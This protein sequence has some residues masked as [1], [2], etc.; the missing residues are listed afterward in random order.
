MTLS[1]NEN[2]LTVFFFFSSILLL[3]FRKG[4]PRKALI[5]IGEI[6]IIARLLEPLFDTQLRMIIS[7]IGIG[8]FMMFFP[9]FISHINADEEESGGINLGIGFVIA[10]ALSIFFRALNSSIDITTYGWYQVIG[11]ILGI[12]ETILLLGFYYLRDETDTNLETGTKVEKDATPE[13]SAN[14]NPIK[15]RASILGITLGLSSIIVLVTFVFNGTTVLARW[16]E[17]NYMFITSLM[18]IILSLFALVAIYKPEKMFEFINKS[19]IIWIWNGLF[20]LSLVLTIAVNQV[21]FPSTSDNFPIVVSATTI[22]HQIPL[23]LLILLLPIIF[24]DFI[25]LLRQLIKSKPPMQKLAGSFTLGGGLYM[26]LIIFSI[27][28]T[29]TWGFVKPISFYFR[30]QFW[31]VF[32]IDGL[33]ILLSIFLLKKSGFELDFKRSYLSFKTKISAISLIA[34]VC[35]GTIT[36][37]I[38]IEAKPITQTGDTSLKILTYNL[39]QGVDPYTQKNYDGQLAL[40]RE[41]DADIIGLQETSKIAGNSDVV[42]YFADKLNM[43]SYFGPRGVT[44]TTGVALLSKYP[45]KNAVT[46]YHFSRDSDR[47]QTAT[48]EAEITI[49]TQTFTIYVTHTYGSTSAKSM[50]INDTLARADGKDNVIFMGD[51]NFR[52]NS[53]PYNLTTDVLVDAWLDQW[54]SGVDDDSVNASSRI[55]HIFLGALNPGLNIVDCR[56][57]EWIRVESDHPAC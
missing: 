16:T 8:C 3:F 27:I 48:I 45:I 42:Q 13:M 24:I 53:E 5:V 23:V 57:V 39:Q 38:L 50:L 22:F 33:V 31:L 19:G 17:G 20:I 12:I 56:Y 18:I 2:A 4:V 46:L 49:G 6:M 11:W 44:G 47:K 10:L 34:I 1:L 30:D 26:L 32:L 36:G 37:A 41:I 9:A 52:E 25:L 40:I 21:A 54:P 29:S 51:F 14:T 55:D 28:F 35:V 7:G 43:Y 15:D